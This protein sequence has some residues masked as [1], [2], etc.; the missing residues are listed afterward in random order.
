MKRMIG[1]FCIF[2]LLLSLSGC[3]LLDYLYHKE[4]PINKMEVP[5]TEE[6]TEATQPQVEVTEPAGPDLPYPLQFYFSSGAGGWGTSLTLQ[7]DGSFTGSF[8]DSEMGDASADYP[9]GTVYICN[10]EGQFS[11]PEQVDEYTYSMKLLTF[12]QE[13]V[14]GDMYV[15]EG[16]RYI[17]SSPYGLD[18]ADGNI[19]ADF[20]LYLPDASNGVLS[21]DALMFWPGSF[22]SP[23]PETLGSYCLLNLSADTPFFSW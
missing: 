15:S 7:A 4:V 12:T 17:I 8:H 22:E 20:L 14:E 16:I 2:A 11:T 21:E 19:A 13:G 3:G 1:I 6:Q 5:V 23:M 18:D 9:N 10:F